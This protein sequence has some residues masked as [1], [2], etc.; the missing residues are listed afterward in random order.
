M[1]DKRTMHT[2]DSTDIS[3]GFLIK[4]RYL[5]CCFII[6]QTVFKKQVFV[7][8]CVWGGGGGEPII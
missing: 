3:H 8:G 6:M 5:G 4:M 2:N 1:Q 7:L